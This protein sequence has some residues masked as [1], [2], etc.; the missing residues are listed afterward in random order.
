MAQNHSASQTPTTEPAGV[1][2]EVDLRQ[3][4]AILWRR[5][6]V[7]FGVTAAAVVAAALLS[8]LSPAIY[9]SEVIIQLSQHSAP[10]FASPPSAIQVLTSRG[11]LSKIAK[12][13]ALPETAEEL[14]DLLK[15][16]TIRETQMVRLKV[17]YHDPQ[18]AR[19]LAQAIADRFI[20][21]AAE[22]V[23]ERRTIVAERL[24]Q[25][26]AQLVQVERLLGLSREALARL[27]Q[28]RGQP[29]RGDGFAASFALDATSISQGLHEGLQ[30]T[31]SQLQS[32]LLS[33][34]LPAVIEAPTSPVK[35]I[36]PRKL[37]NVVLAA[38]LGFNGRDH[39]R[40]RPGLLQSTSICRSTIWS[41]VASCE[42]FSER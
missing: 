42:P 28:N 7:V 36:A 19:A 9:E 29:T 13:A 25:V 31:Q 34:A 23:N 38:V 1:D 33:L 35:P 4:L 41:P 21:Q 17:R 12:M 24:A 6:R 32:E 40:L 30:Q 8:V 10:A 37:L 14:R 39:T 5:R 3:Y 2:D 22:H 20:A 16:E 18:E 26:Q 15:V 11:F 27:Q